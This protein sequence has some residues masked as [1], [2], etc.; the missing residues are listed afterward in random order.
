M[1]NFLAE[2]TRRTK[3]TEIAVVPSL[4]IQGELEDGS[5]GF[6]SCL[7]KAYTGSYPEQETW[8]SAW[9]GTYDWFVHPAIELHLD[10]YLQVVEKGVGLGGELD[11]ANGALYQDEQGYI[12]IRTWKHPSLNRPDT[13]EILCREAYLYAPKDTTRG[14]DLFIR[15]K[16]APCRLEKPS[17]NVKL[18]DPIAGLTKLSS[19]TISLDNGD[20]AFDGEKSELF[21]NTPGY[22]RKTTK[23]PAE[24]SDF[25]TVLAGFVDDIKVSPQKIDLVCNDRFRALEDPVCRRITEADFPVKDEGFEECTFNASLEGKELPLVYGKCTVPLLELVETQENEEDT[26]LNNDL[27]NLAEDKKKEDDLIITQGKYLVGEGVWKLEMGLVKNEHIT[28]VNGKAMDQ[29]KKYSLVYTEDGSP[30]PCLFDPKTLIITVAIE[31]KK[32]IYKGKDKDGN[33]IHEDTPKVGKP[34]YAIVYGYRDHDSDPSASSSGETLKAGNLIKSLIRRSPNM[35]YNSYAFDTKETEAYIKNSP[36]VA[37]IITGGDVKKAISD[38]LKSDMAFMIQKH[39]GRF[40]IRRFSVPIEKYGSEG[41]PKKW[42]IPSWQLTQAPDINFSLAK[43][44]YFSFCVIHYAYDPYKKKHTENYEHECNV[45]R[46]YLK[47]IPTEFDTYLT[48]KI[49]AE[50]LAKRLAVRFSDLSVSTSVGLGFDCATLDLLDLVEL[51]LS[52]N[53]RTYSPVK[54]WIIREID[55]AQDK[56]VLEEYK[57]GD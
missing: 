30:I 13:T 54:Q 8:W 32:Y 17:I 3:F 39:D 57:Y 55:R 28:K 7:Y 50:K 44:Q 51:E 25:I 5:T 53:G 34:K 29:T 56:L 42:S 11:K 22:I 1:I 52:V 49:D 12:Y 16:Y 14:Y 6:L 19:F 2:I 27:E 15:G 40:T 10:G 31:Q 18:S 47:E 35:A 45:A 4:D 9:E 33:S 48:Q 21:F 37:G 26:Y 46:K 41:Y 24:A 38:A 20:G 43:D 36:E 23:N